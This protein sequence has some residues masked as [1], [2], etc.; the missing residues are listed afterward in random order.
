M[1]ASSDQ[2]LAL[3]D[4]LFRHEAGRLV[5]GLTRSLGPGRL[6]LAEDVVQEALLKAM[7][8]WSFQPIPE[9]PTAWLWKVAR[10]GALD[11]LRSEGVLR[12]KVVPALSVE[13][14][15]EVYSPLP[16]E[17][18]DA[19]LQDDQLRLV[20]ICCHPLLDQEDQIALT[21]KTACG[22]GVGEVARALLVSEAAVAKRLVRARQKLRQERPSFEVPAGDEKRLRLK[23]VL[24]VLYLLFNEGYNASG[25][26]DLIRRDLCEEA[27]R[28]V[29][30]LVAS[31]SSEQVP[32][33][34]L[35]ALMLFQVSRLEAR[36]DHRGDILPLREQDRS[37]W[38]EALIREA[39]V[40]AA[41]AWQEGL[42]DEY[43]IQAAIA[44]CHCM[45]TGDDDTPW[46]TIL[47]LYDRLLAVDPSPVVALNRVVALS[48]VEGPRAGLEGLA[49]IPEGHRL[50]AYYLYYVVQA[51]LLQQ[52]GEEPGATRAYEQ[53]LEL[54]A[55]PTER[56]FITRRLAELAGKSSPTE[57]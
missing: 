55:L 5:A 38:D 54:T 53:A 57:K 2:A 16:E 20:F 14:D 29:K 37:R 25:G 10:R 34:G 28:L 39:M 6:E 27:I 24:Q 49:H 33:R 45:A 50:H 18:S 51:D 52:V 13:I 46:S 56:R 21:L 3:V 4:H 8:V 48:R 43:A 17:R 36:L 1:P 41:W 35:L 31:P 7:Q 30:L 40:H 32:C 9:N 15:D 22:F 23:G 42:Y 47:T 11:R 12:Q 19:E 26:E 44:A